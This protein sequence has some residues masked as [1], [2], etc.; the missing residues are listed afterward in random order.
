MLILTPL[1]NTSLN[2]YKKYLFAEP[3]NASISYFDICL[4][5]KRSSIKEDELIQCRLI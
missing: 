3:K 5:K 2:M 4:I 1:S